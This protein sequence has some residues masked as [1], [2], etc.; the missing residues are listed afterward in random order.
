MGEPFSLY[1]REDFPRT[2]PPYVP[3]IAPFWTDFN[4]RDSGAIF[5]RM[6]SEAAVLNLAEEKINVSGF[7]PTLAVVI[8]WF[9]STLLGSI[10]MVS[11]KL[12]KLVWC[13]K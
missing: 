7:V 9:Q 12:R 8:T 4:F 10:K 2:T 3:L 11:R 1:I 13:L 6:T 5:Y